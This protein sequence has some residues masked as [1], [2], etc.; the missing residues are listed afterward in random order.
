MPNVIYDPAKQKLLAPGTL[1]TTSGDALD[2]ASDNLQVVLV[3]AAY[4]FSSAHEFLDPS[5]PAGNRVATSAN[6][7]SLAVSAAG[8]FDAADVTFSAVSGAQVT[9]VVLFKTTGTETTS[10]LI[11]YFDT[12]TG[13]P[14]TP[15][16]GDITIAWDASGIMGL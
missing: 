6:L 2:L 9:Q 3:S 13:L 5:L 10:P 12:M 7:A 14:V 4:T 16:G 8:V 15:N 1:G 11:L